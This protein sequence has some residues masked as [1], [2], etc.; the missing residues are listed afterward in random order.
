MANASHLSLLKKGVKAWN[1]RRL[2]HKLDHVD[3]SKAD[4]SGANLREADLSGANLREAD[5]SGANLREA[6]LS[7]ANL[8]EADLRWANL[9]GANLSG[10]FLIE[11]DLRWANLR[12]ADLSRAILSR[13]ILSRAILREADLSR[14]NL[15]GANLNGAFLI[16]ADLRWANLFSVVLDGVNFER[17]TVGRTL[18]GSVN[19]SSCSG[20]DSVVHLAPSTIGVDSIILSKGDIPEIFLRGVG[21]P[22][23]WITYIPSL[24]GDGIQFFSCFISYSSLDKPFAVRLHDTLQ[25]KG[26]RCW[27]DEKQLLPGH[28]ISRELERGIYLWDKFL[29]CAS[30][31]SLTSWWVEDEIK[32]TL[33]KER[34]LRKERGKPVQKLIPL[35]LDGYMFTDQWDLG[36]LA[37]EIRSRVAA[38]FQDWEKPTSNFAQQVDRVIKA[39]RADEGARELPPP[40]KL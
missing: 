16:E 7:G 33:Q 1:E 32:T 18:F 39:L 25:S 34:A 23:E 3:L 38:D 6:N 36:V 17:T 31:N 22:D 5:L 24:I 13:A 40:S 9:S 29:L 30:K 8:R 35:N 2:E 15:S 10:A 37:N 21:L 20:L 27:L 14:A 28:D 26:I 11:A 12:E 19:L 4:L